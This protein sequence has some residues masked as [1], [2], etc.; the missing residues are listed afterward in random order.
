MPVGKTALTL[1]KQQPINARSRS[2]TAYIKISTDD[3]GGGLTNT[4]YWG[5]PVQKDHEYQLAVIVQSQPSGDV[6]NKVS[7][8]IYCTYLTSVCHVCSIQNKPDASAAL[9]HQKFLICRLL[10]SLPRQVSIVCCIMSFLACPGTCS[11][12]LIQHAAC[13]MAPCSQYCH[14]KICP[15]SDLQSLHR[16]KSNERILAWHHAAIIATIFHILN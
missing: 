8:A 5:I 4:G 10:L 12:F 14:Q 3:S 1:V 6:T 11:F 9:S 2:S 7:T 15:Q 13:C 16:C